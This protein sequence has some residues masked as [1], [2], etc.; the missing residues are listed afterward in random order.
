MRMIELQGLGDGGK[1][2]FNLEQLVGY[3]EQELWLLGQHLTLMPGTALA[4]DTLLKESLNVSFQ[5]VK[6]VTED[7]E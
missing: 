6:A 5:E 3:N 2:R 7:S 1:V 4:L